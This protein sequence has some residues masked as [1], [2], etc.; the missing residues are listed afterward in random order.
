VNAL[1]E[2][3][4]R[5]L[6]EVPMDGDRRYVVGACQFRDRHAAVALDALQDLR[7]PV[8][9]GCRAQTPASSRARSQFALVG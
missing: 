1:D 4:L 3:L 6:L 2:T 8:Y 7:P 9:G 5:E